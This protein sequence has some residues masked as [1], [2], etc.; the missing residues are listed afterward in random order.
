MNI[1]SIFIENTFAQNIHS[2]C[3]EKSPENVVRFARSMNI[4]S[5]FVENTFDQNIHSGC[6][7][8]SPENV[9]RFARSWSLAN[10]GNHILAKSL[11]LADLCCS[12]SSFQERE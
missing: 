10:S 5:I 6:I 8:K 4:T 12:L 11:L 2:G 3:I 7:E 1:T 9:V